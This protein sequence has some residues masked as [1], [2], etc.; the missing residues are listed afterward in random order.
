MSVDFRPDSQA[1]IAAT[2]ERFF[3]L[4]SSSSGDVIEVFR[5]HSGPISSAQFS[6][7]GREIVTS[8]WDRTARIWQVERSREITVD[9]NPSA[10]EWIN[11]SAV[12]DEVELRLGPND[13]IVVFSR[14]AQN[15]RATLKGHEA[16]VVSSQV[17]QDGNLIVT[18]SLDGTV[19]LWSARDGRQLILL[20][21]RSGTLKSAAFVAG[22][23]QIGSVTQEGVGRLWDIAPFSMPISDLV[24]GA[25]SQMV[26]ED[27][28]RFQAFELDGDPQV[29]FILARGGELD[30]R[31]CP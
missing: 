5:G 28:Y 20:R 1:F 4:N 14:D 3:T 11:R 13:T 12:H 31:L 23:K 30:R 2:L 22:A 6:N 27:Q 19:R 18:S 25:C 15:P 7:D 21:E 29:K 24:R 16:K 17:S 9:Q 8:S 26:L 10:S